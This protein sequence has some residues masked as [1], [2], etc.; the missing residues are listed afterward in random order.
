MVLLRYQDLATGWGGSGKSTGAVEGR[1][2]SCGQSV[3]R[4]WDEIRMIHTVGASSAKNPSP[5]IRRCFLTCLTALSIS[6]SKSGSSASR[7]SR[8]GSVPSCTRFSSP[9][10]LSVSVSG[11]DSVAID[12]WSRSTVIPSVLGAESESSDTGTETRLLGAVRSLT[13]GCH[14]GRV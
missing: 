12:S 3:N 6:R 7:C 13:G 5:P 11:S 10:S 2:I 4:W 1:C 9:V 14:G 8:G